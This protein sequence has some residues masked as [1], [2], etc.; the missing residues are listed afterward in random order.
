M[1][2]K[3][4]SRLLETFDPEAEVALSFDGC[5]ESGELLSPTEVHEYAEDEYDD[6][7]DYEDEDEE[8]SE[9]PDE[10]S[11]ESENTPK[12]IVIHSNRMKFSDCYWEYLH[13]VNKKNNGVATEEEK[14]FIHS[15]NQEK[16][17]L[18]TLYKLSNTK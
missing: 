16:P 1:K 3:E 11:K 14:R 4:L 10:E 12:V 9:G 8:G 17:Y 7:E 18:Y 13:Y 6:D 2:V 5:T 15:I